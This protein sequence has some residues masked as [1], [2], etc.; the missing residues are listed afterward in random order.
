MFFDYFF[1]EL[2]QL[3][4]YATHESVLANPVTRLRRL[5]R[6]LA[7]DLHGNRFHVDRMAQR[8]NAKIELSQCFHVVRRHHCAHAG[9]VAQSFKS[10]AS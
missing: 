1:V 10:R 2:D 7:R 4:D 3:I 6:I 5:H 8:T 9:G